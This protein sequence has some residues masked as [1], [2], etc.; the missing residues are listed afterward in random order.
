MPLTKYC[1]DWRNKFLEVESACSYVG[2]NQPAPSTALH[3]KG[4]AQM[5]ADQILLGCAMA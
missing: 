5:Q 1:G 2:D 3:E 4:S